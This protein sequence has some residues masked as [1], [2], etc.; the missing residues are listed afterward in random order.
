MHVGGP[1]DSSF[2]FIRLKSFLALRLT[3][4][5]YRSFAVTDFFGDLLRLDFILAGYR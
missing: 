4:F 5:W 1:V 2:L 3:F